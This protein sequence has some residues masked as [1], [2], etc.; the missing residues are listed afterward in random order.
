MTYDYYDSE[1]FPH[2]ETDFLTEDEC[3][4]LI[5]FTENNLH[6]FDQEESQNVSFWSKRVIDINKISDPAIRD[7]LITINKDTNY[8][9]NCLDNREEILY[10]DTLTIVRWHRGYELH[11]HADREEQDGSTH[12]FPWRDFASVIYL[13]DDFEGGEIYWPNKDIEYKPQARSLAIFPGTNEFLHGVREV[14]E[15]VRYTIASFFT[16]DKSKC[17]R[18]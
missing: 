2:I 18:I 3:K 13:N 4:Q 6:L 16:Y 5:D 10:P 9:V 7:L 15:G 14:P 8:A 11:P 1:H 12:P 17:I